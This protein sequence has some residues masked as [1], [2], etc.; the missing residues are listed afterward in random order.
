[1]AAQSS[2]RSRGFTPPLPP[3]QGF[4]HGCTGERHE[5][6]GETPYSSGSF[7]YECEVCGQTIWRDCLLASDGPSPA[8]EWLDVCS[9]PTGNWRW[10]AATGF[11]PW[12]LIGGPIDH[13][14]QFR[15]GDP[16]LLD[17]FSASQNSWGLA[18]PDLPWSSEIGEAR[19]TMLTGL[20]S[21]LCVAAT[22]SATTS[23]PVPARHPR[24][25]G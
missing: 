15:P 4:N 17:R 19:G 7:V 23:A 18:T 24:P 1:M 12:E 3:V 21:V 22:L 20:R 13:Q 9:C 16:R 2:H 8:I 5:V 11:G 10:R 6:P 14:E 25:S